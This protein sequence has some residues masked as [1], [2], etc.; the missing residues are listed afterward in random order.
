MKIVKDIEQ[1]SPEWFAIRKGKMTA[2]HA[3]AIG[4]AGKGLETYIYDLVAEEYSSAEKEQ[5]SNEHTERGN[6]LEEVARGIYELENNVDV[7]QVT[8][9]EYD[10]YVGCSPDGL[11]GENGLMEIKSPNDTEYLKYLIFGEGQ[12]DTKYIWQCQMQMLVTGRSWND[13]VIYNPNFKKSMLVYRIIPDK[14]KFEKLLNGFEV[15]KK[16]I[17]EI[18]EKLKNEL[19]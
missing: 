5:F 6:E 3:Q 1:Q 7:E 17:L 11:V 12:I 19:K 9:I 8:F 13:L 15:G 4:N 16:L 14:E 10:E 18:K 2:S